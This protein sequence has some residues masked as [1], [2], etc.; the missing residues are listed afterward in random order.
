MAVIR[1]RIIQKFLNAWP[2]KKTFG[3]YRFLPLFFVLGGAL[4]FSMINWR[5]G[6]VNF[7]H[8]FKKRKAEEIVEVIEHQGAYPLPPVLAELQ[9][10]VQSKS[11]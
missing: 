6:E 10:S 2:G 3:L 1:F 11:T 8:T 5:V 7:Y 9:K 4:E